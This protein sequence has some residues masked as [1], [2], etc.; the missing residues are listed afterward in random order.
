M[1]CVVDLRVQSTVFYRPIGNDGVNG[2]DGAASIDTL[3]YFIQ[4]SSACL[5][6]NLAQ[7][8]YLTVSVCE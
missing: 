7:S 5:L 2:N 6:L 4:A 1:Q 8:Y 3:C